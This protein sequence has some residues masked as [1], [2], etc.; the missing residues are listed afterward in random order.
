MTPEKRAV[1]AI[2][3]IIAIIIIGVLFFMTM[4]AFFKAPAS[5]DAHRDSVIDKMRTIFKGFRAES[6]YTTDELRQRA[7]EYLK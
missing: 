2:I 1:D 6:P 3:M 4:N 7:K 5:P